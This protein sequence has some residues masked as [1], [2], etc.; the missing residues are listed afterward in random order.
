MILD[1]A[2]FVVGIALIIVGANFLTDGAAALARR[3]G[4]SPLMVG[5][6]IVAFGTSAPEL[7]VSLTSALSGNSD[8][9]LGNVVGSNIFNVFGIAGVTAIIAPLTITKSTIRKEI[10]L[11][12]LATLVLTI[13]LFDVNLSG[14]PDVENIIS[15]SEGL[16]LLA[17]FSIFLAYTIAISK[18]SEATAPQVELA[19][20]LE[21][22]LEASNKQK[23]VW[24]LVFFIVGG[25]AAL[26]FG[27]DLFVKSASNLAKAFGVS[28]AIIGLTIVAAGTS[29]P[30]LAT[31]V[32]AALK[33]EQ[34]VAVGNVVG[35]N[36][37]NIFLILGVTASVD[38]IGLGGITAFDLISMIVAAVMLY[39]FGVFFGDKKITRVEGVVLVLCYVAYTAYLISQ[40]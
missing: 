31:S 9:S 27:G 25:L 11:M 37:F 14:L 3:F 13:M 34:E 39:F 12:I 36:I 29:L 4:L 6:T 19:D 10:P 24:L 2:L 15:R 1:I 23:S 20:S 5:L 18:P 38:P 35:S 28:E 17:F 8:I 16:V 7:V 33:G 32:V 40:I 21:V 22:D 26:V 30:E